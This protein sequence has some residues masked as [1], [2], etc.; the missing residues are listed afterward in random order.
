ML[1]GC[2]RVMG[3]VL[4]ALCQTGLLPRAPM[5]GHHSVCWTDAS[6][7]GFLAQES[8]AFS[9]TITDSLRASISFLDLLFSESVNLH[10]PRGD[11]R[12]SL[13]H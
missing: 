12:N 9:A 4:K 11:A 7:Q 5:D 1:A 6:S 3:K 10:K 8:R 13:G 2:G